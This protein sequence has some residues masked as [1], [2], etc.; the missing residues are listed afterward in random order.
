MIDFMN[1]LGVAA[2][3]AFGAII[4][5]IS[6]AIVILINGSKQRNH[7]KKLAEKRNR[8]Q[9]REK[10][11][12]TALTIA[13]KEWETH[14]NVSKIKN[15]T[16]S[17]PDI[18]IFR[19]HKILTLMEENKLSKETIA[20]VQYESFLVSKAAQDANEKYRKD[21]GLPMP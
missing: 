12:E 10:I 6:S 4:G 18:Y 20:Q 9:I 19:Y 5:S 17:P 16:V 2:I 14:I 8:I 1:S 15:F 7:E 3:G 11:R 21:N 13:L